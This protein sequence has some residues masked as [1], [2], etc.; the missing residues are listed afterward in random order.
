MKKLLLVFAAC[1]LVFGVAG[2]AKASF[3][4]GD[5]IRVVYEASGTLEEASDIGSAAGIQAG[6]TGA[7]LSNSLNLTGA[8]GVFAGYTGTLDVAYFAVN[9][10]SQFWTSGTQ[11]G[12]ETNTGSS[13]WKGTTSP[14]AIDVLTSYS[15][16]SGGTQNAQLIYT[17][18]G[19]AT[20]SYYKSL[21]KNGAGI[22]S[23]NYFYTTGTGDGQI[24]LASSGGSG[25]Q[26]IFYW[27]TPGTKVASPISGSFT[28]TTSLVNGTITTAQL[29]SPVPIPP[30]VL[31]LGSG[32]L[33]LIGI[34]RRNLFNF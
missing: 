19:A 17:G 20:Y 15:N 11:G 8:G 23:F 33:G 28:L 18:T 14:A 13:T 2:Q 27:A 22:G 5:L 24:A 31:L 4:Q 21:D 32:L 10:T 6:T 3:S 34:R 7:L 29:S 16:A 9:G 12:T 30:S 26:D 1:L 25:N